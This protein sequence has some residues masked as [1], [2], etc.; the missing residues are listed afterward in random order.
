MVAKQPGKII[1]LRE[2]EYKHRKESNPRVKT[3]KKER[4]GTVKDVCE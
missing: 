3:N 1:S 2:P 4:V